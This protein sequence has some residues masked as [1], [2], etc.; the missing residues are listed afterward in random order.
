MD[1]GATVIDA[2]AFAIALTLYRTELARD[3]ERLNVHMTGSTETPLPVGLA[4]TALLDAGTGSLTLAQAPGDLVR[5]AS[6]Y[7]HSLA[8]LPIDPEHDALVDRLVAKHVAGTSKKRPLS[9]R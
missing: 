1:G 6:S 8:V 7:L 4:P 3:E 2:G 9:R 5:S